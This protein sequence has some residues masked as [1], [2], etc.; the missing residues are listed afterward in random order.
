MTGKTTDLQ[1]RPGLAVSRGDSLF[2]MAPDNIRASDITEPADVADLPH[3]AL[4]GLHHDLQ[5]DAKRARAASADV[6]VDI[7][8]DAEAIETQLGATRHHDA[9]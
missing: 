4:Q 5:R 8:T 2:P 6:D 9:F 1:E 7:R 3:E